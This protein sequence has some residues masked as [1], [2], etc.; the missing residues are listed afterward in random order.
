MSTV[1][2][3]FGSGNTCKN[4]PRIIRRM[5]EEL[6]RVDT[7]KHNVVI[8]WQLFRQAGPNTP[9][10]HDAF[11]EAAVCAKTMG[12]D[13]TA[14]VF[15]LAS[16]EF[17]LRFNVPFIKLACAPDTWWMSER[18][19]EARVSVVVS[20]AGAAMRPP[21]GCWYLACVRAYPADAGRYIQ[22]FDDKQLRAG[23]SDHTTTWQLW[24]GYQP[25]IYECH[26]KLPDSTGP[27]AGEFARTPEQLKEIL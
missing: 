5:I 20:F 24:H 14:S 6:A 18:I 11:M 27:D 13:T 7:K 2:L 26:F 12:Y 16:L 22:R 3:D 8:K 17:L 23:I 10:E 25:N 4:K 21:P 1:I 19:L 15:D 9:L